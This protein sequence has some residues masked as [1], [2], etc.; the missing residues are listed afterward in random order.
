MKKTVLFLTLVTL[1]QAVTVEQLFNV[2]TIQVKNQTV[3][4]SKTYNG[5]VQIAD[6][7]IYT[8][9]LTQ[10]GFIRN[11]TAPSIYDKVT[12]GKKLFE[13]Y[14]PEVY[15]AQIELLSAKRVSASLAKNIETKL[16]LYDV[17]ERNIQ[18]IKKSN[19]ASKYLPF[20]SPYSGI[21]VEKQV[22]EGSAVK[23]GMAVYKIADLSSVWVVAKAYE[24]D[25]AFIQKGS[26]VEVMFNG[27]KVVYKASIDFIYPLVDPVNKTID[28][29][30]TLKNKNGKIQPNAYATIIL[31]N[32][33][34]N[35]LILPNT[36]VVTKGAKHLVFIPS[37]YEGEYKSKMVEAKRINSHEF[38]I[39]SGLKEGAVVVNNSLFLLDSDVVINGED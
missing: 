2:K 19:Q 1:A 6:D 10:D 36:A 5:Y 29:R 27:D 25:R 13:L 20:Y 16:K 23:K 22:T 35:K 24:A 28:F 3:E 38:E 34:Q 11:L 39:I 4:N 31:K 26:N 9:S 33:T 18:A 14:S 8:I 21:V 12:K 30:I 15:K 32:P 7:K 37:E 17:S